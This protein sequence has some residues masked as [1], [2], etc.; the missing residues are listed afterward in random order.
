MDN[1]RLRFA[2]L[3]LVSQTGETPLQLLIECG[4]RHFV[5]T[6]QQN[7][8]WVGSSS[9]CAIRVNAAGVHAR[10]IKIRKSDSG[11]FLAP[12]P[13]A[14][15]SVGGNRIH[16]AVPLE[17]GERF[18]FGGARGTLQRQIPLDSRVAV[19]VSS[20]A[21]LKPAL[22]S[23]PA[24]L[25]A[26]NN[27]LAHYES[28][29]ISDLL[30]AFC[31]VTNVS[32]AAIYRRHQGA[33]WTLLGQFASFEEPRD[34]S[35][36]DHP[37]ATLRL[38]STE[39]R[40]VYQ[41]EDDSGT[42]VAYE[43]A[44]ATLRLLACS[45][46]AS[47]NRPSGLTSAARSLGEEPWSLLIGQR[48]RA[49]CANS[50]EL[51]QL[52]ENVLVLGETGTGKE[53]TARSIHSLW[54]RKGAFVAIN[55]A[56]IPPDLLDAELFGVETGAATGVSGRMG[57]MEQAEGGTLFLD[58]VSELSHH[59]QGKLL[60]VLQEREYSRVGGAKLYKADV[61]IIAASNR[62]EAELCGTAM[63]VDLFFRLSQAVIALLPLRERRGD[64]AELC[65]HF[66][67]DW[68]QR[69]AR[70]VAGLSLGALDALEGYDW[71]GNV[72]E[73]Q[74][75]LRAM[76]A[77]VPEGSLIQRAHVPAP[78]LAKRVQDP[79]GQIRTL[80]SVLENVERQEISLQLIRSRGVRQAAQ[81][82]GLSEGYLYRRIKMLGIQRPRCERT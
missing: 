31:D 29:N 44:R 9:R 14:P 61:R 70:G 13:L 40:L 17:V 56:A 30:S 18:T 66:L 33:D 77:T 65:S 81:A 15:V 80:A 25:A 55:C 49:H 39:W 57:R 7:E 24:A 19:A 27:R 1:A 10:H 32:K 64:L 16:S 67:G 35:P 54:S 21:G 73:L 79:Q 75:V 34:L 11:V 78:I 37:C 4:R 12:G 22:P 58:E 51:C 71:S 41:G 36:N 50:T 43:I 38:Q 62:T 28:P 72:R 23:T 3:S 20:A 2:D 48:I 63:R 53:L 46:C 8:T 47:A 68:E 69:F 45:G 60:R 26:W 6:L 42:P 52:S 59:L 5:H 76:Y 74:N 82:L